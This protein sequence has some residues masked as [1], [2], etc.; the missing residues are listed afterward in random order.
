MDSTQNQN[1]LSNYRQNLNTRLGEMSAATAS[2]MTTT[3]TAASDGQAPNEG[4]CGNVADA[5]GV[6]SHHMSPLCDDINAL[7]LLMDAQPDDDPNGEKRNNLLSAAKRL[8]VAFNEMFQAA[9]PSNVE[10]RFNLVCFPGFYFYDD[11]ERAVRKKIC[12]QT[13]QR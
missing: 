4:Q 3:F 8:A 9:H 6:I 1:A 13:V 12:G 11:F 7:L 10:V 2:I 5:V